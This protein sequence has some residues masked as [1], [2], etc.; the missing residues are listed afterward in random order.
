[1]H[2]HNKPDVYQG[3]RG[4]IFLWPNTVKDQLQQTW[5]KGYDPLDMVSL[6]LVEGHPLIQS[7]PIKD[8]DQN[9]ISNF[10][11]CLPRENLENIASTYHASYHDRFLPYRCPYLPTVYFSRDGSRADYQGHRSSKCLTSRNFLEPIQ[12][13]R[14]SESSPH[15]GHGHGESGGH[16][17]WSV[18]KATIE[19]TTMKV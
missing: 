17:G 14:R 9:S 10:F 16:Q 6:I 7:S 12:G 3:E 8:V 19:M 2:V 4:F 15:K 11:L 1:M 13:A 5:V 18:G